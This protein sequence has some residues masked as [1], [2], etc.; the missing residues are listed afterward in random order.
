MA[1]PFAWMLCGLLA[2][3][4]GMLGFTSIRSVGKAGAAEAGVWQS[5]QLLWAITIIALLLA[6]SL[7]LGTRG[8]A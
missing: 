1:L 2:L 8:H 4:I 5:A 6:F 7:Y 3:L